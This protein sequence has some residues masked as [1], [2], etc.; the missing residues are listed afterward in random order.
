LALITNETGFPVFMRALNG[1]ASDNKALKQTLLELKKGLLSGLSDD[2]KIHFIADAAFYAKDNIADM[3]MAWI[4]RVPGTLKDAQDLLYSNVIMVRSESDP[5]YSFCPISSNYG[6]VAQK[7]V[8]VHSEEMAKKH[9]ITW[10]RKI[11]KEKLKAG[12]ALRKLCRREFAC[13]EDALRESSKW[14]EGFPQ[15][16]FDGL[17]VVREEKPAEKKR[18]RP[19]K[20]EARTES[21]RLEAALRLN[22][23]AAD[24]EKLAFGRFILASNDLELSA[25]EILRNY[26]EQG[27]VERGFRFLKSADFRTTEIL[28][29]NPGRIEA[30]ASIASLALLLYSLLE[31]L[32]RKGLKEN[33]ETVPNQKNK[34]TDKPTLKWVFDL[35]CT[36]RIIYPESLLQEIHKFDDKHKIDFRG[37]YHI[38]MPILK[39]LGQEYVDFYT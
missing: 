37:R 34:P 4:S 17:A 3:P 39:A 15:L 32:V 13:E 22:Q 25:D 6:G 5:R 28:L 1:N 21:F 9:E 27:E 31:Q 23:A 19:R 16:E 26:K 10:S 33:G 14:I 7:W 11:E 35:I 30:I 38:A 12:I 20:D 8:L 2:R 36:I 29:K 18:G 24:K